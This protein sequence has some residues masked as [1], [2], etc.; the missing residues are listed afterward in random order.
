MKAAAFKELLESV[1]DAGAY[2]N[3][4]SLAQLALRLGLGE[5]DVVLCDTLAKGG[6]GDLPTG[7][8]ESAVSAVVPMPPGAGEGPDLPVTTIDP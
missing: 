5:M 6:S 8:T 3:R 1:R 2:L 7:A 4:V